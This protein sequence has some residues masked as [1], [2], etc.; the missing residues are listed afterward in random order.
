MN[1]A[2]SSHCLSPIALRG[3]KASVEMKL[4]PFCPFFR[5]AYK[6]NF[7]N[8]FFQGGLPSGALCVKLFPLKG[9]PQPC[10]SSHVCI[11]NK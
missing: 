4:G 7:V 1:M 8:I 10:V 5:I 6:I 11:F 3:K 9:F 2:K